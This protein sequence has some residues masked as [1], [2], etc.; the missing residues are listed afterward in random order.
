[1]SIK[2]SLVLLLA[3]TFSSIGLLVFSVRTA[4]N[5]KVNSIQNNSLKKCC[6]QSA[7][8]KFLSP[9]NIIA[10]STLHFL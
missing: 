9:G 4:D 3:L 2:K 10:Q 5:L 6:Q 1:M 8:N 7:D